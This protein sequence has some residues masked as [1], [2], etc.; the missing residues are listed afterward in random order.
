[1]AISNAELYATA[2]A[3]AHELHQIVSISSELGAI[4]DIDQ[5]MRKFIQRATDFL[6]FR[7][8]FVGLLEDGKVSVRWS[9]LDGKHGDA[10]Y[11]IPEG[12]LTQ[13]MKNGE[14]LSADDVSSLEGAN[15]KLLAEFLPSSSRVRLETP[16]R[17]QRM[18]SHEH[19]RVPRDLH[20]VSKGRGHADPAFGIHWMIGEAVIDG[21]TGLL[22]STGDSIALAI[23]LR[24]LLEDRPLARALGQEARRRVEK[25]YTVRLQ[26]LRY[27]ALYQEMLQA[28]RAAPR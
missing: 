14:V 25:E 23:A 28:P 6:G 1:V 5:F 19:G 7:R 4:S 18:S 2:R 11:V 9:F 26:A 21:Q 17:A 22:A 27:A 20:Q 13:A 16:G 24:R 8:S 15:Q 3:Q 12:I 10:G